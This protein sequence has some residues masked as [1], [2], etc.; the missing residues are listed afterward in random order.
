MSIK[1]VVPD[2][3]SGKDKTMR[4]RTTRVHMAIPVSVSG[5]DESG[6]PFKEVTE[7]AVIRANGA[8]IELAATVTKEQKLVL[9]NIKTRAEIKCHVISQRPPQ[10]GKSQVGIHFDESSPRF[11]GIMFPPEDWDPAE[12]KRP[13]PQRR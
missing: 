4:P 8:L 10:Q 13:E 11:W 3:E 6:K 2:L 7:T 12:R 9:T 5:T 1:D